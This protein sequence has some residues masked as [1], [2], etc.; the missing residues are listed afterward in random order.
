MDVNGKENSHV[1]TISQLGYFFY[2]DFIYEPAAYNGC[3]EFI[4]KL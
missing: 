4:K 1:C 3:N 2:V